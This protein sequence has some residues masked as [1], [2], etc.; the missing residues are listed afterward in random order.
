MQKKYDPWMLR[1]QFAKMAGISRKSVLEIGTGRGYTAIILAKDYHCVVTSI[2]NNPRK[3]YDALEESKR[4]GVS[5]RIAF[6]QEDALEG[7]SFNDGSFDVSVCFNTLHHIT[8]D[9]RQA[10]I[11]EMIRLAKEGIIIGELSHEGAEFFDNHVH[12]GENHRGMLVKPEW[13]E[14]ILS[15]HG[16]T[17]IIRGGLINV[18]KCT[19]V[20]EYA[21]AR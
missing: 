12:P 19:L 14:E 20:E 6:F 13:V 3:L 18:Y 4:H 17:D 16:H 11:S 8:N 1:H 5:H 21:P 7:L 9:N 2:D 10:F 15:K